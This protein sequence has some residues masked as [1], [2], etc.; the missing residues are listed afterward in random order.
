MLAPA[1]A[2]GALTSTESYVLA[3]VVPAST[4]MM[5]SL[6][7]YPIGHHPDWA[8]QQDIEAR[9]ALARLVSRLQVPQRGRVTTEVVAAENVADALLAVAQAKSADLIVMGTR[10][11]TGL[12]L[13]LGS[14][15]DKVIRCGS[16]PVLV[17]PPGDAR[18][19][20]ANPGPLGATATIG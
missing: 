5:S 4:P 11:A 17:V 10:G 9:N 6:P 2:L 18:D 7:A 13:I 19:Q 20:V 1:L 12:E 14:V 15:A 8:R 16:R 3:R